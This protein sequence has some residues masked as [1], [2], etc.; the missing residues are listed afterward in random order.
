MCRLAALKSLPGHR[1][2]VVIGTFSGLLR[3]DCASRVALIL[4]QSGVRAVA[5]AIISNEQTESAVFNLGVLSFQTIH[6]LDYIRYI[7][8]LRELA[9]DL[10]SVE[11]FHGC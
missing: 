4:V 9:P 6:F 2:S 3:P 8:R 11:A 5:S 10:L 7:Q 1:F